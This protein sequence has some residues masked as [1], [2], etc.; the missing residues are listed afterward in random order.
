MRIGIPREIKAGEGR[1]ALL[2]AHVQ[3]LTSAGHTLV[4]EKNAGALSGGSDKDYSAAGASIVDNGSNVYAAAELIVKVKEI[5][6]PE[7][8]YLRPEHIIFTNIHGAA[9]RPQLGRLLEVGLVAIAAEETHEYGSPNSVLAG[10]VGAFEGVRLVLAP[11]GGTGRHFMRHFGAAPAFAVVIGLGGV[12][13]G[14]LRTLLGLGL[15][16]VGLDISAAAQKEAALTWYDRGFSADT[17]ERLSEYLGQADLVVNCV[18]WD[19]SR[20][21]HLLTRVMLKQMKPRAVIVDIS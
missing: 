8:D 21:D 3:Q 15:T 12:G 4:V 19:K 14:A 20:D 7:Y 16:V 1:V 6:P 2:P 5:L 9:D 11:H 18:L 10:E 13:R 17:I